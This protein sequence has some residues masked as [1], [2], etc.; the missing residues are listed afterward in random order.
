M[1]QEMSLTS[2]G[3]STPLPCHFLVVHSPHN[4]PYE[5]LLIGVG[6][7][8]MVLGIIIWPWWWWSSLYS[9]GAP[10]IHLM[11]SCSSALC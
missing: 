4:P 10:T 3:L 11:S 5:Q 6:L 2:P 9:H 8:A 1:A 7:G